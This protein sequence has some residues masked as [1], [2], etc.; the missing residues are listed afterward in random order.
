MK[1][2]ALAPIMILAMAAPAACQD[3]NS[4]PP[5]SKAAVETDREVAITVAEKEKT[6]TVRPMTALV[7]KGNPL[8]FTVTGTTDGEVEIDF[9]S[10]PP[11][12]AD[13]SYGRGESYVGPFPPRAGD[14]K[15]PRRGRYLLRNRESVVTEPARVLGYWKYQVIVR[16]KGGEEISI[17]PGVIIKEGF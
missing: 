4:K 16:L 9:V 12:P 6:I 13:P 14:P 10:A 1:A 8:K 5:A 2:T 11:D 15:N 7:A 17:D 3:R